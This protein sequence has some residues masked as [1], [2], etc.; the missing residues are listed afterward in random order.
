[1]AKA[2]RVPL[3]GSSAKL[4]RKQLNELGLDTTA[5]SSLSLTAA[6]FLPAAPWVLCHNEERGWG[7]GG[8]RKG[9][10]PAGHLQSTVGT[11]RR[12]PEPRP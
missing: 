8:S 4:L 9:K 2:S 11:R 10:E 7:A 5:F 1:M 3:K 6:A 12:L